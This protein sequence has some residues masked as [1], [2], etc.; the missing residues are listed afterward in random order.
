MQ[1]LSKETDQ[2]LVDLI[3]QSNASNPNYT[4][5]DYE[6]LQFKDVE[7]LP[8]G[9][10]RNTTIKVTDMGAPN[11]SDWMALYYNRLPLT[12]PLHRIAPTLRWNENYSTMHDLLGDLNY[13]FR[14]N[15][16]TN[17]IENDAIDFN[18]EFPFTIAIR[19]KASSKIY[20]GTATLD[21]IDPD[22]GLG[23]LEEVEREYGPLVNPMGIEGVTTTGYESA[24]NAEIFV[25][26]KAFRFGGEGDLEVNDG[27]YGVDLAVDGNWYIAYNF[28]L[29]NTV[30]NA[31]VA[32][33]YD[34]R[35]IVETHGEQRFDLRLFKE[36]QGEATTY[37]FRSQDRT[38]A[39]AVGN[40][41]PDGN[42]LQGF[43]K[44]SDFP[45]TIS[46]ET[47]NSAGAALG[48][49]RAIL[50]A[51]RK[52]GEAPPVSVE[53][54]TTTN[55]TA[56]VTAEFFRQDDAYHFELDR[57]DPYELPF[58]LQFVVTGP[59]G[60]PVSIPADIP[61]TV[62]IPAD[63]TLVPD[64][65]TSNGIVI[66]SAEGDSLIPS[67]LGKGIY[68][69]AG[70]LLLS[71]SN[72]YDQGGDNMTFLIQFENL[73]GEQQSVE[74]IWQLLPSIGDA[75]AVVGGVAL[76]G[77]PTVGSTLTIAPGVYEGTAPISV[78]RY[79][80]I[81][82]GEAAV[83]SSELGPSLSIEVQESRVGQYIRIRE[84]AHNAFGDVTTY[85]SII[86]PIEASSS[87]GAGDITQLSRA[88]ITNAVVGQTIEWNSAVFEGEFP[89]GFSIIYDLYSIGIDKSPT[90]LASS[91]S[92][93][94]GVILDNYIVDV[95]DEYLVIYYY[96]INGEPGSPWETFND[97]SQVYEVGNGNIGYA[98]TIPEI[99]RSPVVIPTTY[100]GGQVYVDPGAI[101]NVPGNP[102]FTEMFWMTGTGPEKTSWSSNEVDAILSDYTT[103]KDTRTVDDPGIITAVVKYSVWGGWAD[104][105]LRTEP[106]NVTN[107]EATEYDL[108][109]YVGGPEITEIG[110]E[111]GSVV[112]SRGNWGEFEI[113]RY[114]DIFY[115]TNG[116]N[117]KIRGVET[118][119][120]S[121]YGSLNDEFFA[122]VFAVDADGVYYGPQRT[123]PFNNMSGLT[124]SQ[125]IVISNNTDVGDTVTIT[126]TPSY[127]NNNGTLVV[128][129]T[130]VI[131]N[132][133]DNVLD[134]KPLALEDTTFTI[135]VDMYQRHFKV[136]ET[137][138]DY[139]KTLNA[140]SVTRG[141]VTY[142][143][144][145]IAISSPG[146]SG[147]SVMRGSDWISG[148]SN[149]IADTI[150]AGGYVEVQLYGSEQTPVRLDYQETGYGAD[151][152]CLYGSEIPVWAEEAHIVEV[153][154][155]FSD[156]AGNYIGEARGYLLFAPGY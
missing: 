94:E 2:I 25:S 79:L 42:Y 52:S 80:E 41:G 110:P 70:K 156:S 148:D 28:G 130:L 85:S 4:P 137:A 95:S 10:S 102:A 81:M 63:C 146:G 55:V 29:T 112:W 141:P 61:I 56:N 33:L 53:F 21:L 92:N 40:M 96:A 36:G 9:S 43:F 54:S 75:P 6:M 47:K 66:Q 26:G 118:I 145:F 14:T 136:H 84:E 73:L 51:E 76:Y 147:G 140:D 48:T 34:L 142:V 115:A 134:T 62:S 11:N 120:S 3:N 5:Y 87:P 49:Y 98:S 57:T 111:S 114:V 68:E 143:G 105:Y 104:W 144:D 97:E 116:G 127:S 99:I 126:Q 131:M 64:P 89:E 65:M 124:M 19:T 108:Q 83:N 59:T 133:E 72:G 86:G 107:T 30:N 129:R 12:R 117:P 69:L 7:A 27:V 60:I 122:C 35:I 113:D 154:A 50:L 139:F 132:N 77:D 93:G 37:T 151:T 119:D 74:A 88:I 18:D 125:D 58:T 22:T 31:N 128:E 32:E 13:R 15:L 20:F 91:E 45:E 1:D 17:D 8:S 46:L 101:P 38:I 135:T 109:P 152:E 153:D 123:E 39:M 103:Y 100:V 149:M 44:L 138:H 71:A 24:G 90:R 121:P 106:F 67:G 155:T 78:T 150:A 82:D 16:T 23:I